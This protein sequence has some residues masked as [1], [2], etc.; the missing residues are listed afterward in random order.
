MPPVFTGEIWS[1]ILTCAT[2]LQ[3]QFDSIPDLCAGS[4]CNPEIAASARMVYPV[5]AVLGSNYKLDIKT[6]TFSNAI[7][8]VSMASKALRQLAL[9]FMYH[10]TSV[11]IPCECIEDGILNL[12]PE[13]KDLRYVEYVR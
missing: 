2:E 8:A 5:R 4:V 3:D 1:R 7:V 6:Y 12:M 9:P 13:L 11:Y 10:D